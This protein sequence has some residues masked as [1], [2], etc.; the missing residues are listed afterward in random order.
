MF[1]FFSLLI[2]T[3]FCILFF[4]MLRCTSINSKVTIQ[5][6]S[7]RANIPNQQ[8]QGSHLEYKGVL[9]CEKYDYEKF[10]REIMESPLS[11]PLFTRRMKLVSITDGFMFYGKL[12]VVFFS[13]SDFLYP[14]MKL[15]LRVIRA[16]PVFYMI[17]DNLNASFGYVDYSL[18]RL[19]I[20]K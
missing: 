18:S 8:L 16:G 5:M 12:G 20:T 19:I 15:S 3:A 9:H 17:S 6:D 1:P 11:E 14:N 7:A 10:P 4:P 13:A 2:K